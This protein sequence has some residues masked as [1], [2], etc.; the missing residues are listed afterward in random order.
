MD[1]TIILLGLTVIGSS[2]ERGAMVTNRMPRYDLER[3]ISDGSRL[4]LAWNEPWIYCVQGYT[5]RCIP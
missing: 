1:M 3:D 5:M 2:S 4:R